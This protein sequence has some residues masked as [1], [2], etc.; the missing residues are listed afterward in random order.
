[1]RPKA[2]LCFFMAEQTGTAAG[3][4]AGRALGQVSSRENRCS[5]SSWGRLTACSIRSAIQGRLVGADSTQICDESHVQASGHFPQPLSICGEETAELSTRAEFI[6]P[7]LPALGSPHQPVEGPCQL[8]RDPGFSVA[9][10]PPGVIPRRGFRPQ[11]STKSEMQPSSTST[12]QVPPAI[13]RPWKSSARSLS[14]TKAPRRPGTCRCRY[15][16]TARIM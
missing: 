10:E 8:C 14:L 6:H 7:G 15:K 12:W 4:R 16:R 2:A 3:R 1:L 13:S 11:I 5:F 9:K